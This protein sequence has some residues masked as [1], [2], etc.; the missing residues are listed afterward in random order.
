[1]KYQEKKQNKRNFIQVVCREQNLAAVSDYWTA[2]CINYAMP[3]PN[4]YGLKALRTYHESFFSEFSAFSNIQIEI[5]QQV[6]EGDR[7]VT[8]TST[9]GEH[10]GTF[11]GIPPTGKQI[12]IFT[13]RIDRMQDGKIAEHWSVSDASRLIQQLQP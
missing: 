8:Y 9:Q 6:A 1:G 11:H 4:N 12:A 7:V 5:L 13:I 10:S 2:D 3:E